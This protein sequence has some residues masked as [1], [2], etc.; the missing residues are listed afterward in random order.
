MRILLLTF[1]FINAI[2]SW[3]QK[4][5]FLN[6]TPLFSN[7]TFALNQTF[8]GNDGIAVQI[9]DFNY[10]L[11]DVKIFHDNGQQ[12]N[13]PTSIWL[14]TPTQHSLYLGYLAVEQ[15]DSINFTIGVPKRY[16]TQAG[17]LAQDI[18]TYPETHPLSFQSPSMYWGW[19]F[20]YMHMIT[21][22]KADSNNDG[23]PNAYFEL[24]NLGNNNQ[25]SVT[26]P[27]IQTT[28]GSQTDLYYNCH[29]DRWLN[30][31]PLSSV[32][33]LHGESGLNQSVMQNVNSQEV[34]TL[35]A[36]ANLATH[37]SALIS[38]KQSATEITIQGLQNQIIE[39]YQVFSNT[40]QKILALEAQLAVTTI[41]LDRLSSGLYLVHV[42]TTKGQQQSFRIVK[43]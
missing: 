25:K 41:P 33:V 23:V 24:H 10:Y 38:W 7:Q 5:I 40:G 14:V 13:L 29:I 8:I 16:N 28:T 39:N 22:G 17:A 18:S 19:S 31:M 1:L 30:Q 11:S 20:G 12:T 37:N 32:G 2:S 9:Q 42:T 21:G 3:S 36:A 35:D 4:N 6:L 15:I 26:L 43:P 34:F 27:T